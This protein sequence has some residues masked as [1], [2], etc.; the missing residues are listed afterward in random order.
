M[1]RPQDPTHWKLDQLSDRLTELLKEEQNPQAT[2]RALAKLLLEE[3]LS[4]H[5]P[6]PKESPQE[7]AETVLR[8]NPAMY[9]LVSDLPL[10]NLASLTS[11]EELIS[12]LLPSR[13][14]A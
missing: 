5:S 9:D 6:K 14:D 4:Q 8:E 13:H 7:F 1:P 12:R 10:P 3:D 11:A 2:M